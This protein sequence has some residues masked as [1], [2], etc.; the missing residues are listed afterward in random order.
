MKLSTRTGSLAIIA[1]LFALL[2]IL[3]RSGGDDVTINVVTLFAFMFAFGLAF[4]WAGLGAIRRREVYAPCLNLGGRDDVY[5]GLPAIAIG[6]IVL[7]CGVWFC[8]GA[9]MVWVRT[10]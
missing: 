4:I 3:K 10:L 2:V 6:A 5:R 7:I 9:I 8:V 1:G